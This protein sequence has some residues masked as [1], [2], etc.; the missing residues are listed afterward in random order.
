[1]LSACYPQPHPTSILLGMVSQLAVFEI[2][3]CV[4]AQEFN[5]VLSLRLPRDDTRVL[6]LESTCHVV[7]DNQMETKTEGKV[8]IPLGLGE[9]V[10]LTII[11]L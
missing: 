7:R 10:V 1:M 4:F 6:Q 2:S 3:A 11:L 5:P 8:L 9:S